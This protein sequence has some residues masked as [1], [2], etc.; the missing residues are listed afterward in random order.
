MGRLLAVPPVLRDRRQ[1]KISATTL[2]LGVYGLFGYHFLRLIGVRLRMLHVVAALLGFGGAAIAILG[3]RQGATSGGWSWS[4]ALA[5]AMIIGA[6]VPG[7]REK[8]M[9]R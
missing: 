3:A 2:A 5:A 4:I 6:A 8:S 1:W 9:R 7:T